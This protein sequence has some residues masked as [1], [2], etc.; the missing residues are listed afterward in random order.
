MKIKNSDQRIGKIY[1][2][3]SNLSASVILD[4][5]EKPKFNIETNTIYQENDKVIIIGLSTGNAKIIGKAKNLA[6]TK[7]SQAF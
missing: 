3:N 1:K 7:R 4:G 2:M 5:E 6:A